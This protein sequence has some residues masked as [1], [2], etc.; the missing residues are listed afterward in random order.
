MKQEIGLMKILQQMIPLIKHLNLL[1]TIAKKLSG[2]LKEF[3]EEEKK[4]RTWENHAYQEIRGALKH[5]KYINKKP[6]I[7]DIALFN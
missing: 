1:A 4:D 7:E 6:T 5:F 2:E 3:L